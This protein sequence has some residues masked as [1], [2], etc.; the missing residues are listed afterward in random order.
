M[1]TSAYVPLVA[2]TPVH[3]ASLLV[4]DTSGHLIKIAVGAAG[5][6]VDLATAPYNS[7][8]ILPIGPVLKLGS[9]ISLKAIDATASSGYLTMSFVQ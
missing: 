8:M 4:C 7:C 2:S 6:E 5:Y 9:R 1:T 3:V